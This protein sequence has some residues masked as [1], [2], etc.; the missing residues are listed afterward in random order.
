MLFRHSILCLAIYAAI[1]TTAFAEEKKVASASGSEE[2]EFNDQFLFN[3]GSNIDVSRFSKG[4]PVVPGTFKT[5]II[6]NG[7][8]N[9]S[10]ISHLKR[11]ERREQ[12]PVLPQIINA[13]RHKNGL[14][15]K[16]VSGR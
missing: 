13:D 1:Q 12:H 3:T 7:Q 2:V 15:G 6:L 16:C 4:N 9:C 11:M 10:Q 14:S 8:K 5:Q